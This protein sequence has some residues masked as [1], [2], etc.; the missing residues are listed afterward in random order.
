MIAVKM[1]ADGRTLQENADQL[2]E[3]GYVTRQGGTWS[4]TQVK[5]VI[6]RVTSPPASE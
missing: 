3:S 6:D 5:R 4:A 1:K 2:N